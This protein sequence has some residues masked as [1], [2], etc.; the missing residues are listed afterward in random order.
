MKNLFAVLIFFY[1][2]SALAQEEGSYDTERILDEINSHY[3]SWSAEVK[4]CC[5]PQE[6]KNYTLSP[7]STSRTFAEVMKE[8]EEFKHQEVVGQDN[9]WPLEIKNLTS[10]ME[11]LLIKETDAIHIERLKDAL[12]YLYWQIGII[13]KDNKRGSNLFPED[14]VNYFKAGL[15]HKPGIELFFYLAQAGDLADPETED[16]YCKVLAFAKN[17]AKDNPDI[18]KNHLL[19]LYIVLDTIYFYQ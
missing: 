15:F 11:E 2:L 13:K 4:N 17:H 9:N 1:S 7:N 14:F 8:Y 5:V 18:I 3:N 19:M 16:N 12:Y 10:Q 6:W